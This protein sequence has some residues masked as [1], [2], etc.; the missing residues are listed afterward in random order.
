MYEITTD[1]LLTL[2][3]EYWQLKRHCVYHD[4]FIKTANAY[5][6]ALSRICKRILKL[7]GAC[8][9]L[10]LHASRCLTTKQLVPGQTAKNTHPLDIAIHGNSLLWKQL[11]MM[12]PPRL[13]GKRAASTSTPG[14]HLAMHSLPPVKLGC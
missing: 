8:P 11:L 6:H 13:T 9:L 10:L 14:D 7:F 12:Q 3:H 1:L 4:C 2:H 5:A